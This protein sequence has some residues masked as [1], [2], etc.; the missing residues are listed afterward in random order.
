MNFFDVCSSRSSFWALCAS[1]CP[2][3]FFLISS[4]EFKVAE[5]AYNI[6]AVVA[7]SYIE[8]SNRTGLGNFV[9]ALGWITDCSPCWKESL[10]PGKFRVFHTQ[11]NL[12]LSPTYPMMP[13]PAVFG[14]IIVKSRWFNQTTN[15]ANCFLNQAVTVMHNLQVCVCVCVCVFLSECVCVCVCVCV[16]VCTR[17]QAVTNV[18][19]HNEE[20]VLRYEAMFLLCAGSSSWT[21]GSPATGDEKRKSTMNLY[22]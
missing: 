1:H 17:S 18:A 5:S 16:S 8:A 14:A 20:K 15:D 6:V 10:S 4:H 13:I 21:L 11:K 7:R 12:L 3:T 22:Q 2:V 19:G 9:H